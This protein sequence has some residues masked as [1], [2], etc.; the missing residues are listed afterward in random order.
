LSN[1]DLNISENQAMMQQMSAL[2]TKFGEVG[3][4]FEPE[5]LQLP[6]EKN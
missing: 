6:K 1:E 3:S 4:Y 2:G 5:V